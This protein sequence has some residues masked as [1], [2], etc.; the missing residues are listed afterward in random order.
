MPNRIMAAIDGSDHGWR[1]LDVAVDEARAHDAELIALHVI[2]HEPLSEALRA[3]AVAEHIDIEEE[4]ARFRYARTLGDRLT[5][6]AERRAREAGV[7]SVRGRSAEGNPA[8]QILDVAA[9]ER[10]DTI[11][12][13]SRGLSDAKALILGS[14]S[15]KVANQATCTC[16]TVK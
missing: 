12:L 7:K 15:H 8:E 6:L 13:G 2:P 9:E 11:V 16:I 3:F 10:V 1:A 4:V 14:V 5:Q